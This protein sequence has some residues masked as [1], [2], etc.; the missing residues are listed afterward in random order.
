ML[1]QSHNITDP[2]ES[3]MTSAVEVQRAYVQA[4]LVDRTAL[5]EYQDKNDAIMALNTLKAAFTT[6][7]SPV[8]AMARARNGG[9]IDPVGSMRASGYRHA[10][11]KER[12]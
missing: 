11:A 1:D 12:T 2:L 5:Q 7:V 9:S 4:H 8:L 3:I 10:K 6:D